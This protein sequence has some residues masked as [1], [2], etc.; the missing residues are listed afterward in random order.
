M[1]APTVSDLYTFDQPASGSQQLSL[2]I[3]NNFEAL[4]RNNFGTDP[5]FPKNAREGM[6]RIRKDPSTGTYYLEFFLA[7]AWQIAARGLQLGTPMAAKK[8]FQFSTPVSVWNLTH[9]LGS[10]PIV[11][12]FDPSW[13]QL[14]AVSS[15]GVLQPTTADKSRFVGAPTVGDGVD[16]GLAVSGAPVGYLG[17]NVRGVGAEVGNADKTKDCYF[18]NDGGTTARAYGAIQMGDHLI[19]NSVIAGFGLAT[20][21]RIDFFYNVPVAG[22]TPGQYTLQSSGPNVSVVTFVAPQAGFAIVVG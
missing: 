12:V 6:E 5:N 1:V 17:V 9:N 18:S 3:R 2:L 7:G 16:T 21:D 10:Q 4:S 22:P 8:L 14:Q 15:S 11:Q 20:T 19:W 13:T